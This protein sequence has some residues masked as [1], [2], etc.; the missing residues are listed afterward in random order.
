MFCIVGY[1]VF[2]VV[3]GAG[4]VSMIDEIVRVFL[5]QVQNKRAGTTR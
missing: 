3:V 1:D 4:L 5:Q 2:F